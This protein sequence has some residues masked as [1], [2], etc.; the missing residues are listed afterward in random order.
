MP[1]S[2]EELK[3]RGDDC[4]KNGD[5]R[6]AYAF[7]SKALSSN[8]SAILLCNRALAACKLSRFEDALADAEEAV[9]VSE[10]ASDNNCT[11]MQSSNSFSWTSPGTKRTQE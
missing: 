1:V 10:R 6:E 7:F 2:A 9:A 5:Y 4:F 3:Q 11:F 8:R